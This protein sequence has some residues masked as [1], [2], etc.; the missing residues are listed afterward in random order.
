MIPLA[1]LVLA[2]FNGLIY[3]TGIMV[4]FVPVVAVSS[5]MAIL[6]VAFFREPKIVKSS[7]PGEILA[8]ADGTIVVIEPTTEKEYFN[9]E[10]IQ[11]SIFMS[12]FNVHINH[13]PADGEIVYYKYHPGKFM[14]ASLPKSYARERESHHRCK[15]HIRNGNFDATNCRDACPKSGYL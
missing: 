11:I 5:L 6:V 10:R 2:A 3:I 1:L 15:N 7:R 9:D 8:P 4:L 14:A 13:V 12:V